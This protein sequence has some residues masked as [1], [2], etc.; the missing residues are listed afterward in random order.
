MNYPYLYFFSSFIYNGIAES[1]LRLSIDPPQH[2]PNLLLSKALSQF[3]IPAKSR[4]L[5]GEASGKTEAGCSP[6]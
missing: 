4:G 2:I 6:C 1:N 5:S 3:V